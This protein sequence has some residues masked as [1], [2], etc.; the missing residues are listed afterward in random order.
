M[1]AMVVRAD[2]G[3][4]T[5]EE[6]EL[7][8]PEPGG[9]EV[10]VAVRA[11]GVNRADLLQRQGK[12]AQ[13]AFPAAGPVVAGMEAAGEVV[14][15]GPGVTGVRA[16]DRV[17]GMCAGGCAEYAVLDARLALPVPDG[18]DWVA[19]AALPSGLMTEYDALANAARMAAGETV[20]ITAA[21]S[22]VGL[23]GV[24]VA[25]AL[26]AGRVLATVRSPASVEAV[27]A[28]G[29]DEAV[30]APDGGD[31]PFRDVDVVVDHVGG[32]LLPSLL[33]TLRV[34]G[35]LVS[36]GRLGS[37]TGELDMNLLALNRL[38]LIG[39]TFRTRT[40]DETAAIAEGAARDLTAAVQAGA[41]RPTI[42]ATYPFAAALA[43]QELLRGAR[44]PGKIVVTV[45]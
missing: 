36:V 24:A 9:G 40:R 44:P 13:A 15:L 27:L 39:V 3:T 7:P 16:G 17:M 14:A 25:R 41:I 29:A 20:L 6:R 31:L 37:R 26:G 23:I 5:L 10:L 18:V 22:G 32:P 30:A 1:R 12:Y 35:R 43:A 34:N 28:N 38:R 11:S 8:V 45:P 2:G 21:S 42:A 33:P 4:G 19:A